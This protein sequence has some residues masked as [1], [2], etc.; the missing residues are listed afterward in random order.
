MAYLHIFNRL[1]FQDDLEKLETE[2]KLLDAELEDVLK[3][4]SRGQKKHFFIK[5]TYIQTYVL[6][7]FFD[8]FTKETDVLGVFCFCFLKLLKKTN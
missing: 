7:V 8:G 5:E 4:I 6:G 1:F 3:E 2:Q